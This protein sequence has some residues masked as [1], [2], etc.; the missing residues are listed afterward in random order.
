[1]HNYLLQH[2]LEN[3]AKRHPDRDAVVF[4][5]SSISYGDLN[6]L[7]TKLALA[8]IRLGVKR[9]DRVSFMMKKSIEAI[10]TIF[11]ILKTGAAYVPI[12]PLAPANRVKYIID[13]CKIKIL[14]TSEDI[15]D[16][17]IPDL[18]IDSSLEKILLTAGDFQPLAARCD[19][20]EFLDWDSLILDDTKVGIQLQNF[21]DSNPSYILHTSGSTGLPKGVVIS[22]LNSLTFINMAAD[23]FGINE[24]DRVCGH[25]PFHFDLSVFDIFVAVKKGA[26]LVLVPEFLSVFPIKLAHYIDSMKIS[27][28]N[29]VSSVLSLLADRGKLERFEFDSLRLV[30]FSGDVFPVKYFR[31]V[32]THM[33]NAQFF[34]IYGQTEANSSTFFQVGEV[35][36]DG[37]W[38]IPIGKAFP[39]FEVFA[40]G[41]NGE[42]ITSPGE[43]GELFVSS[44]TVAMGY[45]KDDAKTKETFVRDPRSP[46]A[47]GRVYK[48]GDLVKIDENGNWVFLGRK[49]QQVKSRGYRIQLDEIEI[50]LN[51]HSEILEAVVIAV[52]DELMGNRIITYISS[53][54]GIQM[55]ALKVFDFCSR[56]LPSYMVPEKIIFIDR[57]PR[58]PTGKIDRKLLKENAGKIA[59]TI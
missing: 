9:G 51:S 46:W 3:T 11:G 33:K 28:W 56:H 8:L 22:H 36:D 47:Q 21:A 23:F 31:V 26:T 58:T 54:D 35:L 17:I 59:Q 1:M 38:K 57:L 42:N 29:S 49:D 55:T 6:R 15:A 40:L 34:N 39:N 20:L 13:N 48:T 7:S 52:P 45:W 41:E 44:S 16:K 10:I 50:T 27:V 37:T 5:E 43:V 4:N 24:N 25:A 18:D 30:L 12:D 2:L 32:R 53:V 19:N 14:V